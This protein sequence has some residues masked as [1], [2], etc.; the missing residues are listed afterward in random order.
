MCSLVLVGRFCL[1]L[2]RHHRHGVP[3]LW[4]GGLLS[5][6]MIEY[7]FLKQWL[8]LDL[9]LLLRLFVGRLISTKFEVCGAW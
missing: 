3:R 9:P 5:S 6:L 8:K 4:E 2:R 1:L 7:R